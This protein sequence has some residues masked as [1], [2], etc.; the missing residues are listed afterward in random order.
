M[1]QPLSPFSPGS[2]AAPRG[3][4]R[5]QDAK[6]P[7][8]P[9][10]VDRREPGREPEDG[11]KPPRD[12]WASG[13]EAGPRRPGAAALGNAAAMTA[14]GWLGG[15]LAGLAAAL[16]RKADSPKAAP[17]PAPPSPAPEA[18]VVNAALFD[19]PTLRS[20]GLFALP[21]G[22]VTNRRCTAEG[23]LPVHE[24]T[25]IGVLDPQSGGETWMQTLPPGVHSRPVV[26]PDGTRMVLGGRGWVHV[27]DSATGEIVGS[28]DHGYDE[29]APRFDARGRVLVSGWEGGG[30]AVLQEGRP[31]PL[32]TAG[33]DNLPDGLATGPDGSVYETGWHK[34]AR[35][36]DGDSGALKWRTPEGVTL[37]GNPAVA[38]DGTVVSCSD[39]GGLVALDPKAGELLWRSRPAERPE[40]PVVSADGRSVVVPLD[41]RHLAGLDL[42]SGEVRW[43][44]TLEADRSE[45]PLVGPGGELVVGDR[46][47]R[48]YVLEAARGTL[49]ETGR[50]EGAVRGLTP[51]PDGDLAVVDGR[52]QVHRLTARPTSPEESGL[53]EPG[54][55]S[56]LIGGVRLPVRH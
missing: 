28:W 11:G 46:S 41:P 40:D 27:H 37:R 22:L 6:P 34:P 54:E 55:D 8:P 23:G 20:V 30:L 16:K 7:S 26:S 24:A 52:N 42:A 10:P 35:A 15:A 19:S 2:P 25:R 53:I 51:L 38:P 4:A 1:T 39:E 56:I 14:Q 5:F 36:L 31:E 29:L 44:A 21:T 13:G 32:W 18:R 33:R 49:L 12:L 45:G 47:G 50:V 43:Q 17:P 9:E 3:E 48:V